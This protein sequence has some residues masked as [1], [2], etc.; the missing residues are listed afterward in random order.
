MS[1][2]LT[3]PHPVS[4]TVASLIGAGIWTQIF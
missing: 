4:F 1:S 3:I 2:L